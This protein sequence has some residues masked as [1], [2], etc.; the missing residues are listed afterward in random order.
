MIRFQWVNGGGVNKKFKKKVKNKEREV[1]KHN[2]L[3]IYTLCTTHASG[4]III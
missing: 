1:M 2:I 4:F 3:C